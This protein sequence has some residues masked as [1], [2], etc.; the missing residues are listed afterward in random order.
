MALMHVRAKILLGGIGLATLLTACSGDSSGETP[1]TRIINSRREAMERGLGADAVGT[2]GSSVTEM[3]SSLGGG[4]AAGSGQSLQV[5]KYIWR[6]AL[7]TLSFLPLASTDP[8][9]GVIV[10][11]WG[12]APASTDGQSERFK[13]T[14]FIENDRLAPDTLR[15]AVFREVESAQGWRS[16]EVQDDVPRQIEDAIL[17][18]ARQLRIAAVQSGEG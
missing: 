13:V 17:T 15:V 11:D 8:F 6:G 3:F 9:S 12:T 7:D 5:N 10:T 14:V 18:R 1:D 2:D 16:A 4:A